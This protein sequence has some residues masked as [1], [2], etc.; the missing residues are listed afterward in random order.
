[1]NKT[2]LIRVIAL[3]ASVTNVKATEIVDLM[4]STMTKAL[5]EGQTV[6]LSGFGVF[7]PHVTPERMG[8]NPK[9][10]TDVTIFPQ[11]KMVFRMS[12]TLKKSFN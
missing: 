7:T 11:K 4:L 6:K 5:E 9:T 10:G 8:R 1:M 2:D 3:K 12:R